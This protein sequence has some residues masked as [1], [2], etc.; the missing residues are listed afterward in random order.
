MVCQ[1][2]GRT[3]EGSE[4]F[5]GR[6]GARLAVAVLTPPLSN[7]APTGGDLDFKANRE[8]ILPESEQDTRLASPDDPAAKRLLTD[9]APYIRQQAIPIPIIPTMGRL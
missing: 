6:C 3:V 7:G 4:A 1:R 5:C 9:P 2:C 8:T